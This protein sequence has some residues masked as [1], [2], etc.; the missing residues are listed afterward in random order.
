MLKPDPKPENNDRH[1]KSQNEVNIEEVNSIQPITTQ[2][3]TI[4]KNDFQD[5]MNSVYDLE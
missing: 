1:Q 4:R 3:N 5:R 2:P